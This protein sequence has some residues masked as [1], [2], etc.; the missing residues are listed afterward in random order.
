M[1][2]PSLNHYNNGRYSSVTHFYCFRYCH[3]SQS[4]EQRQ[5]AD[6]EQ[7]TAES[8]IEPGSTFTATSSVKDIPGG[9]GVILIL[10][11]C[12]YHIGQ[13][14]LFKVEYFIFILKHGGDI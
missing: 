14:S 9:G 1:T 5:F 2:K 4:F 6:R 7:N 10:T 11:R 12:C 3:I 13:K 8:S